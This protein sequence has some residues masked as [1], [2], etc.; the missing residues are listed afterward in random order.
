MLKL[1]IERM[2]AI[3][4]PSAPT[5]NAN[6]DVWRD[7]DGTVYAYAE[8]LGDEFWMHLPDLASFRFTSGGDE[9]AA[10]VTG[11]ATDDL[12]LDAYQRR[13]LPMAL[14]VSGRE[15]LHA[16]AVRSASGVLAL[17]ANSETGKSTI[18]FG[19]SSRGYPLWADDLVAFEISDEGNLAIALPFTMKLRPPALALFQQ[20]SRTPDIERN[21]SYGEDSPLSTICVLRK[22]SATTSRVSVRRLSSGEALAAVL[23]HAWAFAL[24]SADRKRRMINHYLDVVANVPVFELSFPSGLENLPATLDAIEEIVRETNARL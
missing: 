9:V 20:T 24:H 4:S 16:S 3:V 17:C 2:G 23:S 12:V 11:N 5:F 22:E 1:K 15:V 14:Q 6:C 8:S 21:F 18:A 13:I 10:A 7:G 19:L